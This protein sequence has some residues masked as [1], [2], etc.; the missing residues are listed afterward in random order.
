VT[1]ASLREDAAVQRERYQHATRAEKRRLLD[2]TVA[3]TGMHPKAAMRLLRRAPRVPTARSRAGRPRCYGLHV[4]AAVL[5]VSNL[6]ALPRTVVTVST[7]WF[8]VFCSGQSMT[9]PTHIR[10]RASRD[11]RPTP[12]SPARRHVA[13]DTNGRRKEIARYVRIGRSVDHVDTDQCAVPRDLAHRTTTGFT[14]SPQALTTAH[15]L[16]LGMVQ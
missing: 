13:A 6:E 16:S 4:V 14:A 1:R 10:C 8:T 15:W 5:R 12:A 3:V 11:R 9:F 2:E 7:S